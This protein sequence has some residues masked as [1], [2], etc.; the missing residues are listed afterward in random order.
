MTN[1][2]ENTRFFSF[3]KILNKESYGSINVLLNFEDVQEIASIYSYDM[4]FAA[5]INF[6]EKKKKKQK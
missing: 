1:E 5:I 4:F 2:E 3:D 6:K